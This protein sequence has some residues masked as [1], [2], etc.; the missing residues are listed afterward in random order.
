MV[1]IQHPLFPST[2]SHCDRLGCLKIS[3]S[4]SCNGIFSPS[5][6][7]DLRKRIMGQGYGH[8]SAVSICRSSTVRWQQP[9]YELNKTN[10]QTNARADTCDKP[11][12]SAFEQ[13]ID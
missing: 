6:S 7:R 5:P 3:T 2:L 13:S 12:F 11:R 4:F 1:I 9:N 8:D 10:K